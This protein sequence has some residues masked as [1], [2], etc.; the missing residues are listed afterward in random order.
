M[1][2]GKSCTKE[3]GNLGS[4]SSSVITTLC[5]AKFVYKLLNLHITFTTPLRLQPLDF[6]AIISQKEG[7]RNKPACGLLAGAPTGMTHPV[8]WSSRRH[9]NGE[10]G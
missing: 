9:H 3:R 7:Q 2:D 8:P 1:E 4:T 5:Y 10:P 6:E